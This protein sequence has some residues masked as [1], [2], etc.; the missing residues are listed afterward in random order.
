MVADGKSGYLVPPLDTAGIAAC[1]LALLADPGLRR[2]MGAHGR[3]FVE[4]EFPVARMVER[5]DA[6]YE[7]HLLRKGLLVPAPAR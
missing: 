4:R 3:A 7:Q 6:V 5:I 1:V 2:A